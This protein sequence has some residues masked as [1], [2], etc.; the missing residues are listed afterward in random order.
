MIDVINS[1]DSDHKIGKLSSSQKRAVITLI[2]RK[3]ETRDTSR[4]GG[5]FHYQTLT[6][7]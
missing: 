2:E 1:I 6:P 3:V 5:Q 7:N 4:T